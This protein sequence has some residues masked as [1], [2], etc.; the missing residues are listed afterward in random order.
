MFVFRYLQLRPEVSCKLQNLKHEDVMDEFVSEVLP[1]LAANGDQASR[2]ASNVS[3]IVRGKNVSYELLG[4][5]NYYCY[6]F[7]PQFIICSGVS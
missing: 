3:V 2:P 1:K 7:S 6:D 4:Y 5:Y